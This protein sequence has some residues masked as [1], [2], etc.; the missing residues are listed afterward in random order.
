MKVHLERAGL[1]H[2]QTF[3]C[4]LEPEEHEVAKQLGWPAGG[5]A[6][7]SHLLDNSREAFALVADQRVIAML[8]VL[9]R[10]GTACLWLHMPPAFKSAG[11][12]ALRVARLLIERLLGQ[13]GEL[14]IDVEASNADT[15]RMADW[16]GFRTCGPNVEKHGRL[17]HQCVLRLQQR[18]VA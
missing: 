7:Y 15:V 4:E 3:A 1:E 5:L 17:F 8:G 12:G 14:R 13:Y 2:V 6:M 11:F 10:P 16:L 9:S 18:R